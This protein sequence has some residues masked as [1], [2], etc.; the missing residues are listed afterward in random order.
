M[1]TFHETVI[2]HNPHT[3]SNRDSC[4][5]TQFSY[6]HTFCQNVVPTAK[7]LSL[8]FHE[9]IT[10]LSVVHQGKVQFSQCPVKLIISGLQQIAVS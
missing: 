6:K 8:H 3:S 1:Y 2:C 5:T 9:N 10:S 7:L 4:I